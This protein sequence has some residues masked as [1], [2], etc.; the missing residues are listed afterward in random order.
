MSRY[1]KQTKP[2][3]VLVRHL[4]SGQEMEQVYPYTGACMSSAYKG[5]RAPALSK[6]WGSLYLC[7]HLLMLVGWLVGWLAGWLVGWGLTALSAQISHIVPERKLKFVEK[8]LSL[9]GS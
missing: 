5:G 8:S 3:L 9:I 7:S 4:G 2:G 6:F 1:D